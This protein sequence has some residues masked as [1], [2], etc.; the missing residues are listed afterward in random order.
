MMIRLSSSTTTGSACW[1]AA[2]WLA[3]TRLL[4]LGLKRRIVYDPYIA[5]LNSAMIEVR[6]A[7]PGSARALRRSR[8]RRQ[9]YQ[10]ASRIPSPGQ[11]GYSLG[12]SGTPYRRLR[13]G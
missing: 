11:T 8:F 4:H 10:I 9:R 12:S 3:T 1:R 7:A 6:Q 2:V 13:G 5:E